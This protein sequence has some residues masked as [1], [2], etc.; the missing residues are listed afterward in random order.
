MKE[1]KK[2]LYAIK[3]TKTD[4]LIHAKCGKSGKYYELEIHALN[5]VNKLNN[6]ENNRYKVVTFELKEI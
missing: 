4:K 6:K 2:Y 3:D 1:N 5:R